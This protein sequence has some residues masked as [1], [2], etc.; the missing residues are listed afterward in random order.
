MRITVIATGF[1]T[2]ARPA[3]TNVK[4]EI[5]P[6]SDYLFNHKDKEAIV[7]KTREEVSLK[8]EALRS[9]ETEDYSDDIPTF[10][11]RK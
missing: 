4:A 9:I 10:L 2:T 7:E 1:H 8:E 11:R 6:R 5:D 3:R